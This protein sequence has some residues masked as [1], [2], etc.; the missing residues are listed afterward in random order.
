[1]PLPAFFFRSSTVLFLGAVLSLTPTFCRA[2]DGPPDPEASGLYLK[3]R[4]D[5]PV[6]FSKLSA[7]DKVK[8]T[9]TRDVYSQDLELFPAGDRVEL[10]V[11]HL[12]K[13]RRVLN[14][15]WPWVIKAFTPRRQA[16]PVFKTALVSGPAN[17]APNASNERTSRTGSALQVALISVNNTRDVH[18][19]SKRNVNGGSASGE[20]EVAGSDKKMPSAHAKKPAFPTMV[21]EAFGSE[22]RNPAGTDAAHSTM[23]LGDAILPAGTAC[24]ILLLTNVSASKSRPGDMVQARLLEPLRMNSRVVLPAGTL[25]D[26]IVVKKSPP[27]WGSRAG[28]L[29]LTFT[30]ITLPG[31]NRVAVAASVTGAE[32]DQ[33]SHTR[34]D[35]EGQLHG[36]RPG[37]LWMA[38]NL[39]VSGGLAKVADDGTQLVIEAIISTAT[40]IST[41][42]TARIVASCVAGIFMLSR[43]GRDVVLPRFTEMDISL[44]RPLSVTKALASSEQQ[45]APG[46]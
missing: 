17:A 21:L 18:A 2:S 20:V 35:A 36:E 27:R 9:L 10:T 31:G 7:G 43:H 34:I 45:D 26:G 44:D 12:E 1:M 6:K 22:V 38:I 37:K 16:Y 15:H 8:G 13:R 40:D 19:Q 39:G 24:K 23:D 42:G 11:D 14:D 30:G 4:L 28:S 32:L 25:F 5:N 3:V 41:A 46:N 33:R 29:S